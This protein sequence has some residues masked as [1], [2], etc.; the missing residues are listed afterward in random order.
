MMRYNY[1]INGLL[2]IASILAFTACAEDTAYDDNVAEGNGVFRFSGAPS[3]YTRANASADYQEQFETGTKYQLFAIEARNWS[4]NYLQKNPS[5]NAIEGTEAADHTISFDGNNK[6]NNHSLDFYA[7]TLSD[8]TLVPDIKYNSNG[9]PTCHVSY[10]NGALTDVMWSGNLKNQTYKNS[11]KLQLNFEHTL[12]KLHVYAQKNDELTGS[13]VVLKEVKLI[14]YLSGDL[15]LETGEFSSETDTRVDNAEHAHSVYTGTAVINEETAKKEIFSAMAFPTRGTETDSHA[16]G[17][18]VTTTVDGK[19]EKTTTY[20]IKEVD[21]EHTTDNKNPKYKAFKFKPNYEYD[22]VLTMTQTTMVVTVIPRVYDWIDDNS[23][24]EDTQIGSSVTFGGVTWMDRNL[25]ATSA[26]AT[27]SIQSWEAS[28]GFYYQFGRSIPYYLEGSCLDP[29]VENPA[30][31]TPVCKGNNNAENAK[32]FPYVPEHY[33]NGHRT[34]DKG[35]NDCAQDPGEK[36]SNKSFAFSSSKSD[37]NKKDWAS[38]HSVSATYWD[39][40]VNQP[41]P[42]GWRL[43]TKDEFLS[44]VPSSKSAGDITFQEESRKL[45]K[46]YFK[47]E[48]NDVYNEPAQYVGILPDNEKWGTIYAIKRQGTSNAY[49]VRWQIKRVGNTSDKNDMCDQGNNNT[50]TDAQGYRSVLVI[51]RYPADK[52]S[53]LSTS[54]YNT[55]YTD[56]ENPVETLMLPISGYIHVEKVPALI[57]AGSEAIYYTSTANTGNNQSWSFR[58]KFSGNTYDRYLFMW[59]EERRSYGC[60]VRC[61][62]DKNVN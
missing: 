23:D 10:D 35:Y 22:I 14:D 28:R 39:N 15:S 46:K 11:G 25:G 43:P 2:A 9:A 42:K 41:C 20:R 48:N 44:I 19:N 8:K 34:N 18:K 59:N 56:W 57:Y 7:V 61:V 60:S 55:K 12:S 3:I 4:T 51:S 5:K 30:N 13:T 31:A 21:V 26:D 32:P 58:I 27:K 54:N 36:D 45:N 50:G 47:T 52:T 29:S 49:R 6:F 62:R 1:I 17:L 53:T 40:T 16:L 33:T 24:Y 37:N 38:T